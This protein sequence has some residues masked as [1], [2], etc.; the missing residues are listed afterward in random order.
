MDTDLLEAEKQNGR[1]RL[2][3]VTRYTRNLRD[4]SQ[5][6]WMPWTEGSLYL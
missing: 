4:R 5:K 3:Q 1:N 6:P 2:C